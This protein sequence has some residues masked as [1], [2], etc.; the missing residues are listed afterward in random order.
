MGVWGAGLFSDD[1][2]L[3][4]KGAYRERLAQGMSGADAT[5]EILANFGSDV[6]D[7]QDGPPVWLALA[8]TQWRY[9]RLEEHV[10]DRALRII[11]DGSDL[12]RFSGVPKLQRARARVLEKLRAQ[13]CSPPRPAA[14]VRRRIPAQCDWEKGEILGFRRD[15]GAWLTLYVRDI[16][17]T[18]DGDQYP[19]VCILDLPFERA[20]EAAP[21]T[22]VRDIPGASALGRNCFR[23]FGLKKRDRKSERI[24][25]TGTIVSCIDGARTGKSTS[26][27]SWKHF[28]A[29]LTRWL[30]A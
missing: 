18:K 20:H 10:R 1:T 4:V 21:S 27:V 22:P 11:D 29:V 9:G 6:D 26:Y 25:H 19:E 17:Q 12:A 28:D 24:L 23:I 14:T 3:D 7:A 5:S 16:A 15:S 30:G 2:A 13:L 8:A